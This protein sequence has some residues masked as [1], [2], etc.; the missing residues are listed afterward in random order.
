MESFTPTENSNLRVIV[1][2]PETEVTCVFFNKML[3]SLLLIYFLLY[4]LF[5]KLTYKRSACEEE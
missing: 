4:F 5:N 1:K 3:R 2:G